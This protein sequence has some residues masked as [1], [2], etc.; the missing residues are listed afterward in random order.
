MPP[1]PHPSTRSFTPSPAAT[2]TPTPNPFSYS[3]SYFLYHSVISTTHT[4]VHLMCFSRSRHL[5]F[6]PAFKQSNFPEQC[7]M[8]SATRLMTACV[9][10][11][12]LQPHSV[13]P[14]CSKKTVQ[15][16]TMICSHNRPTS[17]KH[18]MGMLSLASCWNPSK[19]L[20]H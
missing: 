19:T 7:L 5:R 11:R 20:K 13:T 14:Q 6:S 12:N 10:V 16:S 1:C 8:I 2:V 15:R 4:G 18:H 17:L 3:Y 9:M